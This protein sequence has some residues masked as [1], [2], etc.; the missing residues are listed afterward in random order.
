MHYHLSSK[1]ILTLAV[2]SLLIFGV[3]GCSSNNNAHGT[4]PHKVKQLT[5]V[6]TA[7]VTLRDF[8]YSVQANGT[9][10]AQRHTRINALVAGQIDRIPV[11]IGS[12]I[13]KG[14]LLFKIREVDYNLAYR[15]AEANLTRTNVIL[16]DRTREKKRMQNLFEAGSA[17]QQAWDRTI[18]AYEEAEAALAQARVARDIAR[19]ALTDCT[20]IAPYDGVVTARYLEKGEYAKK[21]TSVIEIIDLSVLNAELELPERYA[22]KIFNGLPVTLSVNSRSDSVK[23]KIVAVNPKVNILNR[24]FLVKVAVNNQDGT[25]QAGL[26]CSALFHLPTQKHQLAVP[27]SALTRDEG[28]TTIWVVKDDKAYSRTVHE[29]GTNGDWVRILAGVTEEDEII[30]GGTS[31]LIE[32][33]TITVTN[34]SS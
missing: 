18:T 2:T 19:Q 33:V 27:V 17:T 7:K 11:D 31:G 22:G 21:G 5:Q 34:R 6:T 3:F 8:Q 15:Q 32:G 1:H 23:G 16:K 25:L 26:F 12:R 4:A 13:K 20:I 28:R 29:G 9:L 24:T 14:Q 10:V 30:T